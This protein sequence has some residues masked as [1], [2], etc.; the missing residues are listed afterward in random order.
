MVNANKNYFGTDGIRGKI[1][2]K[3]ITPDFIL[4]LGWAAGKILAKNGSR[5]I[6]IGTDT[7]I[8]S[9]ILKSALEA[10]IS[11][12][13][14]SAVFIG[15]MPTPGVAYLT[16]IFFAEAGIVISASHNSFHY[17]GIK[18]FSIKGVK[19]SDHLEK[20]IEL[21]MKK[22]ISCVNS[23]QLGKKIKIKN[24]ESLYINFCK[25]KFSENLN[26]KRL[27]IVLDCA[28]GSTYNIAPT[29]LKD[30]GAHVI[31]IN[32]NPNGININ[33]NCGTTD[34]R[35]LI[36]KVLLEQ[37][38]LG[39]AFDGDGD[40]I[41][42]VD[43]LGNIVNGDHILYIIAKDKLYK[44]KNCCGVVGTIMSNIGL[45]IA[46]NKLGIPF[47]R[48]KIGD[49]YILKK[50]KEKNWIFGAENCGHVILLN[51]STTGD[52]IIACLQVL[53]IMIKNHMSLNYLCKDIN[54]FPQSII[55]VKFNIKKNPL[56]NNIVKK[57]VHYVKN[58]LSGH[59]RV[60]IRKSGTEPFIRIMVEGEDKK[61]VFFLAKYIANVIKS[62]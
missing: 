14:A 11:S 35:M 44:K 20:S 23:F 37:A 59:G 21:T 17:N 27:K 58:K 10:G 49:K 38:D 56:E 54:F 33:Q 6:I 16:R 48:T 8:S 62:I 32:C 52:A 39:I 31:K 25:S 34:T 55:N 7:R 2:K 45:E 19:I 43:H 22:K 28:H 29:V 42:M 57:V 1:G 15:I 51:K 50:L 53:N 3:P 41:L 46:L 9:C 24:A 4:K 12:A 18:F 61:Q 30:L 26:L 5:K 60:L 47:I 36:S 40:R 13:G